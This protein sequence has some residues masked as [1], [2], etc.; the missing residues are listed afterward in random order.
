MA[1]V[2]RDRDGVALATPNGD[3]ML[4]ARNAPKWTIHSWHGMQVDGYDDKGAAVEALLDIVWEAKA[5]RVPSRH[6]LVQDAKKI[7]MQRGSY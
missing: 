5:D 3:D 6:Y 2:S 1:Y 4:F 7:V